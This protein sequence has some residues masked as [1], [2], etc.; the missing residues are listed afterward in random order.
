MLYLI[1]DERRQE[2]KGGSRQETANDAW[3]PLRWHARRPSPVRRC[4]V[5]NMPPT[6]Q[7]PQI[8]RSCPARMDRAVEDMLRMRLQC[9]RFTIEPLNGRD[10]PRG[11]PARFSGRC[12]CAVA[13]A[14]L[15]D[16]M[17]GPRATNL[18]SATTNQTLARSCRLPKATCR[19]FFANALLCQ[20]TVPC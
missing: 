13:T 7:S 1:W 19:A 8:V 15:G 18:V 4:R 3:C 2:S 6:G 10:V 12:A 11:V 17:L 14:R 16:P 5:S 20:T 9:L